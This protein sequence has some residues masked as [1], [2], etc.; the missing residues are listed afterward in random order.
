M[1]QMPPLQEIVNNT[2]ADADDV[3]SN[4]ST[5]ENHLATEVINRD[6]S[7]AMQ[8]PLVVPT[9]T[10]DNQAVNLG[11]IATLIPPGTIW[12]YGGSSAPAGWAQC[13][14]QVV[15]TTD[16]TYVDLFAAIGYTF[17]DPGGGNFNLPKFD[18]NVPVGSG[19]GTGD[20]GMGKTGG[21]ADDGPEHDHTVTHSHGMNNHVHSLNAHKHTTP[22]HKHS[23]SGHTHT[24][25]GHNHTMN[26]DHPQ[27]TSQSRT[28]S[29]IA[30]SFQSNTNL[31]NAGGAFQ[32]PSWLD[33]VA[34]HNHTVNLPN[35]TGNTG[36]S[37][38]LTSNGSGSF[39]TQNAAPT[40]NGPDTTNTGT[41]NKNTTAS[42]TPTTS[43]SGSADNGNYPPFVC[44]SFIIKL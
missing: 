31:V 22:S 9:A 12:M 28:G 42:V 41:S 15:S 37:G 1:A 35:W 33:N 3:R 34:N 6:G 2:P 27:V 43:K 17:G 18:S 36:N 40:T 30:G 25:N 5:I 38:T 8:A 23:V 7:V 4:F 14:G 20:F 29:L 16:P 21:N 32:Y 11:Q 19:Y 39:D 10:Q 24:I 26:H 44:V 13:R